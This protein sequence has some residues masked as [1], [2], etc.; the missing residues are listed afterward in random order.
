MHYRIAI[1]VKTAG[2]YGTY[3]YK[4]LKPSGIDAK[5]YEFK[6]KAEA[7]ATARMCYPESMRF[8]G[9]DSVKIETIGDS[10]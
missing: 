2:T 10:L 5:P 3:S 4:H 8:G 1:K 6:T 7:L 9:D